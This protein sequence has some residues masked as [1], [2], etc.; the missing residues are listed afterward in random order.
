MPISQREGYFKNPWDGFLEEPVFLLALKWNLW[1]KAFSYFK[2]KTNSN[3]A[4]N[5]AAMLKEATIHFRLFVKPHFSN[6]FGF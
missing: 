3:F 4:V 6:V 1:E 5:L 2:P